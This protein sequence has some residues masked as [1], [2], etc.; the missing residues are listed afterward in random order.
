[1]ASLKEKIE[2]EFENIEEIFVELSTHKSFDD[3]SRLE[4]AGVASLLHNFYTGVENVLKQ[5][6]LLHKIEPPR[7]ESRHREFLELAISSGI[8]S[9]STAN[10]LKPYLGFRHFFAH[11]YSLDLDSKRV[12]PLAKKVK[13]VFN[14]FREDIE[15]SCF[16]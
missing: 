5:A 13:N 10:D 12:E 11:A 1:M 8:I 9:S 2:A 4:L 15:N 7:G 14:A 3:L 6:F 16:K